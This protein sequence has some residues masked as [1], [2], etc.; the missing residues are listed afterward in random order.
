MKRFLVG[1]L[2]VASSGFALASPATDLFD[3]AGQFLV[4]QYFGPS[5]ADLN[6]LVAKYR[7]QLATACTSSGEACAYGVAEPLI[8]AMLEELEDFHAYFLNAEAVRQ[9]DANAQGQN[10][11]PSPRLGFQHMG[12][13]DDNQKLLSF[14][15]LI[16][17][18]VPNGPAERAGVQAGDRW[19]GYDSTLFTALPDEAAYTAALQTFTRQ[20]QSGAAVR[21]ILLRGVDRNR[22]ELT[23]QGQIINLSQTPQLTMRA[24]NIAVIKVRDYQIFGIG[25][26]VHTLVS[27]AMTLGAR[28]II[29]D[30]RGNGGGY[31]NERWFS[32]AAFIENP[33]PQR[34]VPRYDAQANTRE[35]GYA[36]GVYFVRTLG[37]QT[38]N[39][40]RLANPTLWRG[41]LA[42]L[43]DGDCASACEYFSSS[44]QRARRAPVIGEPTVGIGSTN[45]QPFK[46]VNGAEVS[47]PTL[48]AFWPDG[49]ALPSRVTPDIQT[50][51][52]ELELFERGRDAVLDKALETLYSGSNAALSVRV[53]AELTLPLPT[54]YAPTLEV[55]Q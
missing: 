29:Y 55:S 15:R 9:R 20:V 26:Q 8:E 25:Q 31:A 13:A 47:L 44:I 41:A 33:E 30:L 37:G 28:G 23:V 3:Q 10:I 27:R 14:D 22:L 40:Q 5:T 49:T 21:M 17:N 52:Y 35:E 51:N 4:T 7:G 48:R 38:L 32:A 19:I 50:K 45:T 1:L 18:V 36:N 34:R 43:V 12:F 2:V 46:L 6:A 16:V 54:G 39:S 11:A 53:P 42:V 24:D